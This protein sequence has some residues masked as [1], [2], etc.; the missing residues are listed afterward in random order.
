MDG[1]AAT[2]AQS[3]ESP[4]P[5]T[6]SLLL[7]GMLTETGNALDVVFPYDGRLVARV[8]SADWETCDRA[9]ESATRAR[10]GMAELP[11]F[12]RAE[13][14]LRAADL[15][16]GR[17]E[18]LARQMTLETGNAIWETRLEVRRTTEI[19]HAASEEARRVSGEVVPI[20]GWPNGRGRRAMTRRYPVGPVLAITPYNAPLLLVAHK[21]ASAF[22]AGNPCIVRPASKTPLSALSLGAILV[23]AG[24]PPEAVSVIPSPTPVAEQLVQDERVKMLSFTGS[25]DVGW[26]LRRIARTAR[27]TLELGGNGA[28]I[29]HA[30]ADLEYAADRC[31]FGGFLRAGQ[32]CISVQRLYVQSSVSDRFTELFLDRIS[33]LKT[34]DP[35]EDETIVGCLV[36]DAA[37]AKAVDLISEAR[38]AG[39]A[40]LC[41]GTRD[42]RVVEPALLTNVPRNL[43]AC[44]SEAFAPIVVLEPYDDVDEAIRLAD[45]SPYGLQAGL[46]TNDLRIVE[47]AVDGLEVGALIVNDANT[48]RVDHMPYGGE[49]LSGHGREGVHYAIREMTEE[50]LLVIDARVDRP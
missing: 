43:R 20:D 50:R 41:G 4:A 28:V 46:F 40:V 2:A 16:R 8:A 47:R 39:A 25:G 42:G 17:A 30:D 45:D 19:L 32:A 49:K 21:L 29:I 24:A 36:D 38:D 23:E 31:A 48:F 44:A 3:V 13:I 35:L 34:G 27:V 6:R 10:R 33:K 11:P 15:V 12:E 7:G 37:A 22:A 1:T 14:L 9:L 5:A 18:E 26:K